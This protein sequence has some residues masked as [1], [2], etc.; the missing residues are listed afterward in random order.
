MILTAAALAARHLSEHHQ[1]HPGCAAG[2]LVAGRRGIVRVPCQVA[3][4]LLAEL[5][6]LR[7]EEER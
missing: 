7:E 1:A 3:A 5:D 6:R 4:A 2:Q